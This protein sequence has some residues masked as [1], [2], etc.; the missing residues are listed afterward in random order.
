MTK[1]LTDL[2]GRLDA[3][4][5][6]S[7]KKFQSRHVIGRYRMIDRQGLNPA[8]ILFVKLK[9]EPNRF[10]YVTW[11]HDLKRGSTYRGHYFESFNDGLRDF[12]LRI[13]DDGGITL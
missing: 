11:Q 13:Q 2:E 7:E 6:R 1:K 12:L 4:I 8:E 10:E 3:A 9:P 5:R